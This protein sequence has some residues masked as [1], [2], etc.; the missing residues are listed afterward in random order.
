MKDYIYLD[1]NATTSLHPL[2]FK[3]IEAELNGPPSNPS[4]SHYF[5]K[6]AKK[7]LLEA[8]ESI[9]TSLNITPREII[10]TSGGTE[11]LNLL[12][13]GIAQSKGKGHI[14][15]TDIEHACVYKNI[16]DLE[17]RGYEVT[18]LKTDHFGAPTLDQIKNS[19]KENTK[20]IVLSAVNSETGVITDFESIA[21][22]AE[23]RNIAF[24]IDG[25]ALLGKKRFSPPKGL[26][27]MGFSSHKIHGPKGSGF[28]YLSSKLSLSP[29]LL[30]GPQEYNLRAGTENLAGIIGTAKAIELAYLDLDEG[31]EKMTLLRDHFEK[32]LCQKLAIQINGTGPRICNT[33]NISFTGVDGEEF[34]IQL[35]LNKIIASHGSAC[36]SH[37]TMIS[38]ILL[39]MGL[40]KERASSSIRFS[41]CRQNTMEE[42]NKTVEIILTILKRK[43]ITVS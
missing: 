7:R 21:G 33:S 8:K 43:N 27:A 42:I 38:R 41:F 37:S 6:K 36:Q 20:L 19:V 28:I 23:D 30:G 34:L 40:G 22:F 14:I 31:V 17:K 24:V 15:T 12:I 39:N 32:L 3:E 16:L 13:K 25:V 5:G 18:Y 11:S 9:A 26:T 35:D 29:L 2:V 4:A 1:N 10:F